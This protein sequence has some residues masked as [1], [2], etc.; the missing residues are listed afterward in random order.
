MVRTGELAGTAKKVGMLAMPAT[1]TKSL[2]VSTFMFLAC[3]CGKMVM[4][5]LL[6]AATVWP[7]GLARASF[8]RPTRP[9]A[10][11]TF[12]TTKP[13]P[14]RVASRS[15]MWRTATSEAL[16]ACRGSTM[17]T[18]P[19]GYFCARTGAAYKPPSK[20]AVPLE[21]RSLRFMSHPW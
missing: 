20:A 15:A 6:S 19:A 10:A 7:S 2:R 4:M 18:G 16:P 14:M 5:L 11:A 17:L 13:P 9:A 21:S 12:S 1:G 3:R 8:S